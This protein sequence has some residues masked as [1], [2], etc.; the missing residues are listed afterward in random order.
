MS[1]YDDLTEAHP[2]GFCGVY[3]EP[4][5][6]EVLTDCATMEDH[7]GVSTELTHSTGRAGKLYWTVPL[8]NGTLGFVIH[9]VPSFMAWDPQEVYSLGWGR[10]RTTG[11]AITLARFECLTLI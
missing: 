1:K 10:L 3:V 5:D 9:G 7:K 11:T 6:S 4:F 8:E 2:P